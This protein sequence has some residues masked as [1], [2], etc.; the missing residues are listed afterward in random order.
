MPCQ[1]RACTE[2]GEGTDAAGYPRCQCADR[3]GDRLDS[4]RRYP[5]SPSGGY[6]GRRQH[7]RPGPHRG[8]LFAAAPPASIDLGVRNR[9]ATVAG[10][11]VTRIFTKLILNVKQKE[12]AMALS[13]DVID[14]LPYVEGVLNYLAPMAE[15]PM[16]LAYDP[17]PGV[18]RSTG[19]P[20]PHRV[21]IHD[22]RPLAGR[23]SLD[24]EG[25]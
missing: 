22:A 10:E 3:C 20:E 25:L 2:Y 24:S 9:A 14:G 16:N 6:D 7:G 23:L 4:G 15:R 1:V 19:E 8:N 12:R 17:S 5:R 18:P 21:M 11:M 13:R